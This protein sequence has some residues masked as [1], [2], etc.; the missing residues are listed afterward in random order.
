MCLSRS[1]SR[2]IDSPELQRDL[3]AVM[4]PWEGEIVFIDNEE[5]SRDIMACSSDPIVLTKPLK[6]SYRCYIIYTS[7][8][9]GRPKGVAVRMTPV[10]TTAGGDPVCVS[11]TGSLFFCFFFL[12]DWR[13][14]AL[15]MG[16]GGVWVGGHHRSS[17]AV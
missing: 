5:Q 1:R 13:F 4:A 15:S 9:T 2:S 7:G 16:Y 8:S 12:A 3:R 10:L 14:F 17:T 11:P 6:D